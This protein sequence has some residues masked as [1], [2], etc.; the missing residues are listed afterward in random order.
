MKRLYKCES[1][2]TI[3][4]SSLLDKWD[5]LIDEFREIDDKDYVRFLLQTKLL[6]ATEPR[7]DLT[8]VNIDFEDGHQE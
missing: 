8:P 5:T 4:R 1:G 6:I 3:S 7:K 2:D